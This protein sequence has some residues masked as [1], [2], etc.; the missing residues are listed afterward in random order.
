MTVASQISAKPQHFFFYSEKRYIGPGIQNSSLTAHLKKKKLSYFLK[1]WCKS[2]LKKKK[3]L[4]FVYN[5]IH[6]S[7]LCI[8]R[9]INMKLS[10]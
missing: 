9:N 3:I 4:F 7:L 10:I 8:N 2:F 6:Y 5:K 1:F